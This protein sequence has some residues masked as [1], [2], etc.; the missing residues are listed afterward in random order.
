[1]TKPNSSLK[2]PEMSWSQFPIANKYEQTL[3]RHKFIRVKNQWAFSLFEA[4]LCFYSMIQI[5]I[6]FRAYIYSYIKTISTYS[7]VQSLYIKQI[8]INSQQHNRKW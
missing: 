1:M 8:I 3:I 4:V 5:Y 2:Q 6:Q 7:T